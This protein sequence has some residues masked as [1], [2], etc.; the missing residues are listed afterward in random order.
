[1][2]SGS[3]VK[4]WVLRLAVGL[5]CSVALCTTLAIF[6]ETLRRPI[7]GQNTVH[8]QWWGLQRPW[9]LSYWRDYGTDRFE[10]RELL[11]LAQGRPGMRSDDVLARME[12]VSLRRDSPYADALPNWLLFKRLILEERRG[13]TKHDVEFEKAV[14]QMQDLEGVELAFGWP[15]RMIQGTRF[16]IRGGPNAPGY[17][18]FASAVPIGEDHFVPYGINWLGLAGN[19][20]VFTGLLMALELGLYPLLGRWRERRGYCAACA[21]DLRGLRTCPECGKP[22]RSEETN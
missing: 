21:Y 22:R 16:V 1:M 5:G 14:Q 11:I 10:W 20:V 13:D 12:P 4:R 6:G 15:F 3:R 8:Q 17:A 19:I 9:A 2:S 18:V 7:Q